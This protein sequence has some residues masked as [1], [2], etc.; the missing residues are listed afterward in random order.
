MS[1]LSY[2][3]RG[4]G[5]HRAVGRLK[6]LLNKE[7]PDLVFLMENKRSAY[8]MC[9]LKKKLN[10]ND[11]FCIDSIGRLGGLVLLCSDNI[12]V[13][14]LSASFHYIDC[15]VNGLFLWSCLAF[16]WILWMG[17]KC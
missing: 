16:Y 9:G 15:N 2:N 8:E 17:E 14:I 13:D 6:K 4:I 12:E 11:G 1:A 10:F 7:A 5:N 3:C